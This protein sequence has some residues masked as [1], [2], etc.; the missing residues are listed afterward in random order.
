M[1]HWYKGVVSDIRPLTETT[2]HY[3]IKV[4]DEEEFS[5]TP[6]QFITLDLPIGEKRLQRWRSYSIASAPNG[7]NHIE[8]CIVRT[9]DGA[10]TRYFFED[11]NVGTELKFKG[12]EGVFVIPSDLEETEI[13]LLCTGTGIAPFRSMLHHIRQQNL[14]F[15]KIHL[16]FGTRYEEGILYKDELDKMKADY[17]NFEYEVALSRMEH[18]DYYHGYIHSIYM[19]KYNEV[20]QDRRFYVCG[21]SGMLDEAVA[22]L[23]E[24]LG[25]DKSQ[26][27]FELYG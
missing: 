17:P 13:V 1:P 18:P 5:F 22:N 6:G 26:I 24:K 20:T 4:E 14:K 8:L 2:R 11:V 16:I 10:G 21:W 3:T 25:Y 15:K 27:R 7:N 12:P 9:D 23:T 19:E